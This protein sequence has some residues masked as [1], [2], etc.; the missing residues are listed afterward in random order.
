MSKLYIIGNGFDRAHKLKTSYWDFRNYLEK[1]AQDFLIQME[2][3]YGIA[4]FEKRDKR[5]KR[6]KTIQNLRDDEIS[7][8]LWRSFEDSLGEANEAEM[9]DYSSTVVED[10]M[11]DSGPIGIKDTLDVYW[12]EQYRFIEQLN[13]YLAKWIRQVRLSKASPIKCSFIDNFEDYFFTFNYTSVLERIYHV[14]CDHILHIHGGLHPYCDEPPIL[15]HGNK[16]K[17]ERYRV[18]AERA[19]DE[20]NEGEE[21][22]YNAVANYYERTLKDTNKCIAF[23]DYFFQQLGEVDVVEIIGHSYGEVDMPYFAYLKHY[24][25]KIVR[26]KFFCYNVEDYKAAYRAVENLRLKNNYEVLSAEHFW[27]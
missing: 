9:L 24:I 8:T 15:G 19:A 17:I 20:Y 13:V 27:E 14:P 5:F 7:R 26:W 2:N 22:I 1:Y 4:P 6:N 3:M 16:E 23:N 21:S 12:E 25:S 10:L 11:L 18:Q